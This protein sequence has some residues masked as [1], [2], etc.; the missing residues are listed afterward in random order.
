[1]QQYLNIAGGFFDVLNETVWIGVG[2]AFLLFIALPLPRKFDDKM[3]DI[4]VD[5]SK[6]GF[7]ICNIIAIFSISIYTVFTIFISY[8]TIVSIFVYAFWLLLIGA[9]I[10]RILKHRPNDERQKQNPKNIDTN[11][12]DIDC[13]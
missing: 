2:V 9:N 6:K 7:W 10:Y 13:Q 1:M 4:I 12:D 11:I 5:N 3:T 8:F